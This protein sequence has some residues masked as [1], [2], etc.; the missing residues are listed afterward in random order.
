MLE[1]GK[2]CAEI[3]TQIK[4][5]ESAITAAKRGLI[6]DHI[7]QCLGHGDGNDLAEM[8]ALARLL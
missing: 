1:E 2:P 7:D 4:A 5:V 3:T 8:R 6:H